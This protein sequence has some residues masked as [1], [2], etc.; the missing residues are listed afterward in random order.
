MSHLCTSIN[1]VLVQGT[2]AYQ[3]CPVCTALFSGA[4]ESHQVR[5]GI[6]STLLEQVNSRLWPPTLRDMAAGHLQF[7]MVRA[8]FIAVISFGSHAEH[9]VCDHARGL[10]MSLMAAPL[11]MRAQLW[12][13]CVTHTRMQESYSN[14]VHLGEE[15]QRSHA[16]EMAKQQREASAAALAVDCASGGR[17]AGSNSLVSLSGSS[18]VAERPSLVKQVNPLPFDLAALLNP[19]AAAAT[20]A[21]ASKAQGQGVKQQADP[22]QEALKAAGS[23]P[24]LVPILSCYVGLMR[25]GHQLLELRGASGIARV[26]FAAALGAPSASQVLTESKATAAAVGAIGALVD[27]LR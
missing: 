5:E 8:A 25:T 7:L 16:A 3:Q 12:S 6:C 23:H 1:R 17:K 13:V 14:L 2:I 4:A 18:S 10:I 26:C 19:T 27:L 11:S 22:I 15:W 9:N 20:A 24:G 21:A